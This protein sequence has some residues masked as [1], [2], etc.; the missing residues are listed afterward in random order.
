MA[1][2]CEEKVAQGTQAGKKHTCSTW[3]CQNVCVWKLC[4]KGEASK[5]KHCTLHQCLHPSLEGPQCKYWQ[6]VVDGQE[7]N[8]C[9][10]RE[11]WLCP[12]Q[13]A[14]SLF[15]MCSY[16]TDTCWVVVPGKG[17]S[18]CLQHKR[19]DRHWCEE[20]GCDRLRRR[21]GLWFQCTF[22]MNADHNQSGNRELRTSQGYWYVSS[23]K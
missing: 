14:P 11:C 19:G 10:G 8:F 22:T 15:S 21:D 20:R 6:M 2:K 7:S 9:H 1:P 16:N 23:F 5:A 4:C 17:S 13:R 18:R 3:K 12:Q